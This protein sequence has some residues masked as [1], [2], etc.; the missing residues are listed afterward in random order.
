MISKFNLALFIVT[1][2]LAVFFRFYHLS[3]IPPSPTLDEV[4]IGWNAYS[5]L[6]TG[7]DEYGVKMP[8]LLRAYDD[9]RP[10]LYVYLV[11]P[12]VKLFDFDVISVRLP[13]AIL[14]SISVLV[15]YFLLKDLVSN[16]I[17]S[18]IGKDY[19]ELL[20]VIGTAI[21][22]LSP[23]FVYL[24]RLGHEANAA[25]A[26]L[27]FAVF[28]L[29]RFIIKQKHFLLVFSFLF[30][31]LS[32][33]SY[34]STK[35]VVPL[36]VFTAILIF[37][38]IF[39]QKI[40]LFI[41]ASVLGL[42]LISPV[43]YE[44]AK[45]NALIRFSAT[46]ILNYSQEEFQKSAQRLILHRKERN[47]L[48]LFW[49]NRR[50]VAARIV[51]R[52]YLSH[53]NPVWLVANSEK[54]PF[55]APSTGLVYSL[56]LILFIG[57]FFFCSRYAKAGVFVFFLVFLLVAVIPGAITTDYPHAMRIFNAFIPFSVFSGIGLIGIFSLISRF[58]IG[59]SAFFCLLLLLFVFESF[60]FYK[61]YFY[62]FPKELS[63][64][65]QYGVLQAFDYAKSIE[66]RY[67]KVVVGN[68][69]NLFQSYM[70]YLFARKYDPM[71]YQRQGGTISA[72]FDKE[73]RIG[74]Y[75]FGKRVENQGGRVL[76]ILNYG[77]KSN[78]RFI[79]TIN[80]LDGTPALV[81]YSSI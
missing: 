49:D 16:F 79:K 9:W 65:F 6:S 12:F 58:G 2:F 52:A 48:G 60:N 26:F 59:R 24:S 56:S 74:K 50:V 22:A 43:L 30:F 55:K 40:K 42:L 21:F 31:A 7:R 5:I 39:I 35:I 72:G 57:G 34:Q 63:Y 71:L 67:D 25:F 78:A 11:L 53:F 75:Y 15:F 70:F 1:F 46:N 20:I 14:S 77:E 54:E 66:N 29:L 17:K 13:S 45:P 23:W 41:L 51:G 68:R 76:Y 32:F 19:K 4:S 18:N 81:I 10:A 64:Q 73:H 27:L 44:S 33:D 37:R 69:G 61:N 47:Y 36:L 8:V 28:F 3:N 62:R 38:E 80:F